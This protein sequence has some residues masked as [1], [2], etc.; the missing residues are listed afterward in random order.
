M[1]PGQGNSGVTRLSPDRAWCGLGG[2]LVAHLVERPQRFDHAASVQR[3]RTQADDRAREDARFPA[4]F[5]GVRLL[6][7]AFEFGARAPAKSVALLPRRYPAAVSP[8]SNSAKL[9]I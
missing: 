4:A 6:P 1:F 7:G 3:R 2:D 8:P 9:L 5:A